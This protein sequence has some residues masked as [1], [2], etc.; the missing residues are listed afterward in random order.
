MVLL[1][2]GHAWFYSGGM[3]SFIRGACVVLFGGVHGFIQ[4]VRSFIWGVHGFM[5]RACMVSFWG[6]CV[7]LFRG[8]CVVFLGGAWFFQGAC[9]VFSV[10][11][12]TMR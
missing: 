5:W 3:R 2:G 12:D 10:F 7:V 4:G 6:A 11:W 9:M 8:V 1:G